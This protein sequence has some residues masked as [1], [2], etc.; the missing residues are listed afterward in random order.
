MTSIGRS[1]CRMFFGPR[2]DV[3]VPG[4]VPIAQFGHVVMGS[5][6]PAG[7]LAGD[8]ENLVQGPDIE[9]ALHPLAVSIFTGIKGAFGAS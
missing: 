6:P 2:R 9:F 7:L 5:E 4:M 1:A 3:C 8:F